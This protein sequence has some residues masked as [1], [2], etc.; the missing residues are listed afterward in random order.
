MEETKEPVTN[1][2][3]QAR[4]YMGTLNNPK[5]KAEVYLEEAYA[6]GKFTYVGG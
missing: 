5:T 6:S 4:S 2:P 3:S 1:R